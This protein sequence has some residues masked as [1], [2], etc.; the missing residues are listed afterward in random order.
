MNI[1][2]VESTSVVS[3][4]V[5]IDNNIPRQD[6]IR[7]NASAGQEMSMLSNEQIKAQVEEM[8]SQMERMDVS[9][10]YST[11]GEHGEKIAVVIMDK[12]T[13]DVIRE[14]PAKEIQNLYTKMSELTGMIF[15]R[16]A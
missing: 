7:Q 1:N 4:A 2:A 13:G 10:E 15:N 11:Y 3:A 16:Q 14:I 5:A 8:Q 12:Q 6:S 9:L